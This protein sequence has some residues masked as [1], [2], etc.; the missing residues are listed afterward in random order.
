MYNCCVKQTR[1]C[2][3]YRWT[4]QC[5]KKAIE[6]AEK[7][8]AVETKKNAWY[9]L[10]LVNILLSNLYTIVRGGCMP[11]ISWA[12]NRT[13]LNDNHTRSCKQMSQ[14]NVKPEVRLP[15]C[16]LTENAAVTEKKGAFEKIFCVVAS[17]VKSAERRSLV[18][19]ALPA[20]TTWSITN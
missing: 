5:Y 12:D 19:Q 1:K 11:Y 13:S 6:R 4:L 14:K 20:H 18:E 8:R 10:H 16:R 3:V 17:F 7:S 15:V 2:L 9:V